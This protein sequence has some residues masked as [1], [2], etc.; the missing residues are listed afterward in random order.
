M[1]RGLHLVRQCA[2]LASTSHGRVSGL[3]LTLGAG[4]VG[5]VPGSVTRPSC[6]A[7]EVTGLVDNNLVRGS[8]FGQN[9]L[10]GT[11]VTQLEPCCGSISGHLTLDSGSDEKS[12]YRSPYSNFKKNKPRIVQCV[13][14][15]CGEQVHPRLGKRR[16]WGSSGGKCR[17]AA[18][19]SHSQCLM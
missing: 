3:V 6:A 14:G 12:T 7:A 2:T 10:T 4:G 17:Q 19:Q 1:R 8:R 11:G 9:S 18:G 16:F 15:P 5:T 13:D